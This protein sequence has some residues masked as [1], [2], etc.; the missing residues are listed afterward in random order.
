[1]NKACET[2]LKVTFCLLKTR[3]L[4]SRVPP[5]YGRKRLEI[6]T[7]CNIRVY[8]VKLH[9]WKDVLVIKSITLAED[10][11]VVPHTHHR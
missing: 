3:K 11:S 5:Q 8:S 2:Q 1:M 9:G 10:Y 7:P 6:T 4:A